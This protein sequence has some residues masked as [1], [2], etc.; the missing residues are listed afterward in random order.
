MAFSH[1]VYKQEA[2]TSLVSPT[3][4]EAGLP[5]IVGTAPIHLA[6]EAGAMNNVNKPVLCYSYSE[7]VN[8]FGFSRDWEKY[9]LCEFIYSQFALYAM[10]PCVLINVLD[11]S[12]HSEAISA[13]QY[14]IVDGEVNLGSEAI[15]AEDSFKAT[16]LD[17][18]ED[19]DSG[20][21]NRIYVRDTDYSVS[22]DDNGSAIFSVISGGAL[23][24]K[25]KVFL[26]YKK[27]KPELI[28]SND[29]IGGIDA[30]TGDYSGFELV[31][32]VFPKFRLVPGLLGSPK[33]SEKPEVAAVMRAKAENINGLFTAMAVVDIPSDSEGADVYTEAPEWKNANNYVAEHMTVCWPKVKLGDDVFCMSTQ[34]I[35]LMNSIDAANDDVPYESPS[36]K[37]LQMNACV[38]ASGKEVNLG[39]EQ[40]NYLNGQ[41]IVTAQN[42]VG[43]WRAW[44]NR[45]ACYPLNTDIKDCFIPD[46]RMFDWIGNQFILMFWQKADKPMTPRLIRTI[47]NS[48]NVYLN[49]LAAREFILGG[50]IEFLRA[51]NP[52]TALLD[53]KLTFRVHISPPPPAESTT[54]IFEFDPDYLNVLFDAVK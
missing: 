53:G 30:S 32:Q 29:I 39:S 14:E 6:S 11:P 23:S 25:S 16:S 31:N 50:L 49:G 46:R 1:G 36:N 18:D 38:I 47:V 28:T 7:A 21:I 27:L 52:T 22:Y 8:Q 17:V 45:T 54:G 48:F 3:Q 24:G 26:S 51:E 10:S 12:K 35:G 20:E 13:R 4:T 41:G 42:W 44:G 33:W 2:A 43:G 40:V 37:Q 9:T 34:L 19:L 15:I 5:V